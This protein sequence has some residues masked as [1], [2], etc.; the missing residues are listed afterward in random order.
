MENVERTLKSIF[1]LA[2]SLGLLSGCNVLVTN[3][4]TV[5]GGAQDNSQEDT[6]DNDSSDSSDSAAISSCSDAGASDNSPFA[7]SS[8]DA[9]IG[10]TSANPYL[11]CTLDQLNEMRNH[12]NK[13]FRLGANIDATATNT[14]GD[15]VGGG[16]Y[17]EGWE[18]VGSCSDCTDPS[19]PVFLGSFDGD[20]FSISNLYMRRESD[21]R[22]AMFGATC[23][24]D[25]SSNTCVES[26]E[27]IR[28]LTLSNIA[29][30]GDA[31]TASLV[32]FLGETPLDN[33]QLSGTLT[34]SSCGGLAFDSYA[35]ISNIYSSLTLNCNNNPTGGIVSLLRPGTIRNVVVAGNVNG[36]GDTGGIAGYVASGASIIQ[37]ASVTGDVTNLIDGSW[38]LGG[39]AGTVSGSASLL[40]VNA[41]MTGDTRSNDASMVGGI[42]GAG[43]AAGASVT[44]KNVYNSGEVSGRANIGGIVGNGTRTSV[45][46][47]FNTGNVLGST[48]ANWNA[49][50]GLVGANI[51][52][53]A[54]SYS[55]ASLVR[56]RHKVGG[57]AGWAGGGSV[58]S[59][60][61]ASA[62]NVNAS[63][64]YSGGLV[65]AG[66]NGS[67][68]LEDSFAVN[69][70]TTLW[71][72]SHN[73]HGELVGGGDVSGTFTNNSYAAITFANGGSGN[74]LS[75]A[76]LGNSES[77]AA[78][79]QGPVDG[80]NS[81]GGE[82]YEDWDFTNTWSIAAG[83]LP[84]LRCPV[85]DPG[86]PSI[87]EEWPWDCSTWT[88]PQ[89]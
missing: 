61:Y 19:A 10:S 32:S 23:I 69:M 43:Q 59:R 46:R 82:I 75:H 68:T 64:Y 17:Y 57:V 6:S 30:T 1:L 78:Y 36:E 67:S 84:K 54:D 47:A 18:P 77:G 4:V 33:I 42:L 72:N 39:I 48:G 31:A 22:Q 58:Y 15:Y 50:G 40:V 86:T 14:W 5:E 63:Q 55:T 51:A 53:I 80:A 44:L 38:G 24:K 81:S 41:R 60:V 73:L 76:T 9:T 3:N 20:G 45:V 28:D 88:T 49:I 27:S 85:D 21:I 13:H 11:I 25:S 65:G 74:P 16:D 12:L 87:D 37:N 66:L 56:G 89:D 2:F 83:E 7:N 29:I 62:G 70:T 71:T 52:S 35:D 79:F 34:G 26:A 8:D